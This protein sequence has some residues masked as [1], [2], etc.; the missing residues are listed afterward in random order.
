MSSFFCCLTLPPC[1]FSNIFLL[2]FWEFFISFISSC[3][4]L[5]S[6]LH[7]FSLFQFVFL[8]VYFKSTFFLLPS[9]LHSFCF[10]QHFTLS[11][12]FNFSFTLSVRLK[13]SFSVC[14]HSTFFLLLSTRLIFCLFELNFLS[15]CSNS[16]LYGSVAVFVLSFFSSKEDT[17]IT[18]CSCSRMEMKI[19]RRKIL[20]RRKTWNPSKNKSSSLID[21]WC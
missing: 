1:L 6:T 16:S 4:P 7:S 10:L 9:T 20:K 14:F 12:R 5:V 21:S 18:C 11:V 8:S 13:S 3:F 17:S 19:A 15:V 2:F